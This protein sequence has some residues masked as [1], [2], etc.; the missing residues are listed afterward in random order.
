MYDSKHGKSEEKGLDLGSSISGNGILP[1]GE[2]VVEVVY[3]DKELGTLT[4]EEAARGTHVE[5]LPNL[6]EWLERG[7]KVEIVIGLTEGVYAKIERGRL[8]LFDSKSNA[9]LTGWLDDVKELG[10]FKQRFKP[11]SPII[12]KIKYKDKIWEREHDT[13]S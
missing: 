13:T 6:P 10:R 11:A 8:A 5:A 1:C 2:Y 3:V 12:T 4:V 7:Q 9:N